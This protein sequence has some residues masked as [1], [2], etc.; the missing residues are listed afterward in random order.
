MILTSDVEY[1]DEIII[2]SIYDIPTIASAV[3]ALVVRTRRTPAVFNFMIVACRF[4][5]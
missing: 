3:E 5:C 2:I 1:C 4:S